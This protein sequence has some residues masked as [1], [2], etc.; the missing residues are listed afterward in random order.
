MAFPTD[1]EP[2]VPYSEG[3]DPPVDGAVGGATPAAGEDSTT[4]ADDDDGGDSQ[5]SGSDPQYP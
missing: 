3:A 2:H 5:C 4:A 1:P